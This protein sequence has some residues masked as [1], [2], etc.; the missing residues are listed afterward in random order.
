MKLHGIAADEYTERSLILD[1]ALA[2]AEDRHRS[3]AHKTRDVWLAREAR[4]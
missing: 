3:I 4:A 1:L 2:L